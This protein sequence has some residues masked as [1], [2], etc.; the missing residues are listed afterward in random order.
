[1]KEEGIRKWRAVGRNLLTQKDVDGRYKWAKVHQHWTKEDWGKI[2]WSD[3]CYVTQDSDPWQLW[4]FRC[5]N[6][7]EKYD[8]KNI[9]AKLKY[10]R[11]KQMVWACFC[12]NKLG[13]IAF[14]D[15]TINSHVYIAVLQTK[16]VPFIQA[17]NEDGNPDIVF[18]QDNA[19]VH[20]SKLTSAWLMDSMTENKFSTMVWP[21][22]SPDMNPIE[23]LWAHLKTELHRHYP[24]TRLLKGSND[25]IKRKLQ[26]RL[27]EVW[28]DIG[29]EVLNGLIDSMPCRVKALI[30]ARGWYTKY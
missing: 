30:A 16:L 21:A 27:W 18:Q 26:D 13:P 11:V 22:Y 23:E 25:E 24:D 29:E 12:G 2:A 5:Q 19:K 15:G 8:P 4:V 6:K 7:C 1:M 14:A 9:H 17:L 10:G 28:W 20:T 3:E